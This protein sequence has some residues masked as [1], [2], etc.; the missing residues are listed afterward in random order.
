MKVTR[1]KFDE[2][3]AM[4]ELRRAEDKLEVIERYGA[5]SFDIYAWEYISKSIELDRKS[6]V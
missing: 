2:F 1:K 5:D 3:A 4:E 6:V